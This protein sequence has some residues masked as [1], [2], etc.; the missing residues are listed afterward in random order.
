MCIDNMQR[1]SDLSPIELVE[2]FVT[3]FCFLK[4]SS[5]VSQVLLD[6]FRAAN[7]YVFLSEFVIK[8]VNF[9]LPTLFVFKIVLG[10]TTIYFCNDAVTSLHSL[11]VVLSTVCSFALHTLVQGICCSLEISIIMCINVVNR[12][13]HT[14]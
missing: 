11:L 12:Y 9:C 7:G 1:T 5:D 3:A 10:R 6:D 8:L 14:V 13:F 4:D 2:M